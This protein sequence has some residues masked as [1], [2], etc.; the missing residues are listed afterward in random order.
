M[1]CKK[2]FPLDHLFEV[3]YCAEGIYFFCS[4]E[5]SEKWVSP[6]AFGQEPEDQQQLST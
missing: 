4:K 5:C 1:Q 3:L 2:S 6:F